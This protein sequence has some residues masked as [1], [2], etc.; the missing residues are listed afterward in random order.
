[1]F[2]LNVAVTALITV[3]CQQ[4]CRIAFLAGIIDY[5]FLFVGN[6]R[7]FPPFFLIYIYILPNLSAE[8]PDPPLFCLAYLDF[9]L[10]SR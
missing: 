3:Y 4:V 2:G 7:G 6:K 8:S 1:M 9:V 5:R 10:C